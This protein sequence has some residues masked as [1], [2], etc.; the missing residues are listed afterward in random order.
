[1]GLSSV[2][3]VSAEPVWATLTHENPAERQNASYREWVELVARIQRGDPAAMAELY[4]LFSQSIRYSLFRQLGPQDL[5]D[6]L[7]DAFLIV[8]QAIR[9]DE[10]RDP[11]R[12]MGFVRTV[13]RRQ[14]AAHI[15][16]IVHVRTQQA[17]LDASAALPAFNSNPEQMVIRR[18]REEIAQAALESICERDRQILIRFYLLEQPVEEICHDMGLSRTQF[19]L[20]KSRAKARFGQLGQ[21]HMKRRGRRT[22]SLKKT[23]V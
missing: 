21:R 1:M 5:E 12:L 22:S 10:L 8:V 23:V 7:H 2:P 19:R 16:S 14:V 4:R 15:E 6:M 17:V 9:R 20:L 13:V 11:E 18:Q 3:P